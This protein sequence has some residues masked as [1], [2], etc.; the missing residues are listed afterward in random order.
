[1]NACV[2][3]N[4]VTHSKWTIDMVEIVTKILQKYNEKT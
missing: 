1:M 2:S 4:D 3:R